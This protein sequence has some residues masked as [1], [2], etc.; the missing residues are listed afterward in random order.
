TNEGGEMYTHNV[1]NAVIDINSDHKEI[2]RIILQQ[3]SSTHQGVLRATNFSPPT[4]YNSFINNL[5]KFKPYSPEIIKS[6]R[7]RQEYGSTLYLYQPLKITSRSN[8]IKT[9]ISTGC[10]RYIDKLK[11]K[12]GSRMANRYLLPLTVM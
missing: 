12:Y 3:K 1:G 9:K 2:E 7:W 4:S 11:R 5:T 6:T 8:G 10:K